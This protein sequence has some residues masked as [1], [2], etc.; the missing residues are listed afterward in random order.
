MKYLLLLS[1]C[2]CQLTTAFFVSTTAIRRSLPPTTRRH[3][4]MIEA[5]TDDEWHP[6]DPADTIP[7]LLAALWNQ[8]AQ[9]GGMVQGV[10]T[11]Y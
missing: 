4:S 3:S 10:S 11:I 8:I 9:A 7:Q 1:I 5:E 6:H 2:C